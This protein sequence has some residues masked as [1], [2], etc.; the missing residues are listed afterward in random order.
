LVFRENEK[1]VGMEIDL[2]NEL[3]DRLGR[4][5]RIVTMFFPN[6][7]YELKNRRIDL[8]MAGLSVTDERKLE[9]TFASPYFRTGQQAIIRRD[10]GK[11]I[12]SSRDV[13]RIK[14]R[15]GV[16]KGTTALAYVNSSI[17]NAKV[18]EFAT[19]GEAVEALKRKQIQVV[20]HDAATSRW[21]VRHDKTELL[22]TV[23]GLMTDEAI[24]WAVN[25]A[26][27]EL[28]K[29]VNDALQAM[30]ADGTLAR[31]AEKWVGSE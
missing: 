5:L 15:I 20:I 13:D 28:L 14:H 7:P 30:R 26:N 17:R 3:A 23:P 22:Q 11:E 6:L 4:K 19:L 9:M 12:L 16:E 24:A 27:T 29:Q 8:I 18:L 31:L 2:A 21:L 25:P 1:L 10:L